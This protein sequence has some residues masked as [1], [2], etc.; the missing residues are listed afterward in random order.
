MNE[1]N[2]TKKNDIPNPPK[3]DAPPKTTKTQIL[4]KLPKLP[5]QPKTARGIVLLALALAALA[6]DLNLPGSSTTINTNT[7]TNTNGQN[8]TASPSP[9]P[10]PGSCAGAAIIN[11]VRVN[12]FGYDCPAGI[13]KPSNSSGLLPVG[14]TAAVTATPK[15]FAG[16]DV[17]AELHG[18]EILWVVETGGQFIQVTSDPNEAFN[19]NVLGVAGPGEFVLAATVC[20]KRGAWV[21]RTTVQSA[22]SGLA[23]FSLGGYEALEK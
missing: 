22:S 7:A 10:A 5:P 17:P 9:S 16:N 8:P 19:K 2:M 18:T 4:P 23:R 11:T 13:P 14:C 20:G 12:P 15:D 1:E 3:P 6:C 21:G